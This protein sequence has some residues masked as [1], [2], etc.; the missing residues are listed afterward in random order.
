MPAFSLKVSRAAPARVPNR[1]TA[2][3]KNSRHLR[4]SHVTEFIS[5]CNERIAQAN[6]QIPS[7]YPRAIS[8]AVFVVFFCS[9]RQLHETSSL[10]G[11]PQTLDAADSPVLIIR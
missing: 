9:G 3:C 5:C 8:I 4:R 6:G 10:A 11:C 1:G 2:G 7:V